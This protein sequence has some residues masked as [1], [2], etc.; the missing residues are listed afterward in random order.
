MKDK[1]DQKPNKLERE[2]KM[3]VEGMLLL[4]VGMF[5]CLF[6]NCLVFRLPCRQNRVPTLLP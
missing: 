5:V 6:T 2:S 3:V 4:V 1:F